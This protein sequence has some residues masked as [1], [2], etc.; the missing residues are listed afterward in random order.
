MRAAQ[1]VILAVLVAMC[2]VPVLADQV[3]G[4][5]LDGN[6]EPDWNP[7]AV[8]GSAGSTDWQPLGQPNAAWI[9][10]DGTLGPGG[11]GQNF[12]AE[13][14]YSGYDPGNG[15]IYVA[16]VTGFDLGGETVGS[17]Y[18]PGDIF[19]DFGSDGTWDLAFDL[20]DYVLGG[21]LVQSVDAIQNTG[22]TLEHVNVGAHQVS[23][24]EPF[25]V[26]SGGTDIGSASFAYRDNGDA[27]WTASWDHNVYEFGFDL[28]QGPASWL[29]DVLNTGY[30]VHWTM[31]CGNDWIELP[32][33]PV[34]VPPAAFL[35]LL[36]GIA[37]IAKRRFGKGKVTVA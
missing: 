11:G 8:T 12:D 35:G 7:A 4:I 2:S 36:G 30:T 23:P 31:Q 1:S 21:S 9:N 18:L 13:A 5:T 14:L 29:T 3:S 32:V 15:N 16:M 27:A 37:V 25:R 33:G 26:A 10:D 6:V 34:P 20:S 22:W 19:I 17:L 24:P 28:S